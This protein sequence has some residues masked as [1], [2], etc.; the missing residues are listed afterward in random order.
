VTVL[1][2]G[3]ATLAF[4]IVSALVGVRL[5]QLARRTGALPELALG[6]AFFLVGAC[7]YP[8]GLLSIWPA[9]PEPLA[10]GLFALANLATAV[11]SAAV[12]VFTCSVFRPEARWA[13]G[14]VWLAAALLGVQAA[15]GVARALV[16]P[17]ASFA[18][19]D[20]GFSVR[21]AVT[22]FSYAWTAFE[23]LRYRALLVR[24]LA[25]GLA[26]VEVVNRFLLWAVAGAGAFT[27]SAV[28]SAISL[29]G[30]TPWQD[31]FALTAVGLGG[32][33]AAI[34]AALAFLPP[35]A[36]LDWLRRRAV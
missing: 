15:F 2:S 13:R 31:P 24:R 3:A 29:V 14:L 26:E 4:V 27:G 1:F 19:P 5:L 25:L 32:F 9:L 20:L 36:Y 7:G 33:T 16:A 28:M 18:D 34:C 35:R 10:R 17:P 6:L 30:H 11:G 12:F 22:A 23:A 8:L 21:Q